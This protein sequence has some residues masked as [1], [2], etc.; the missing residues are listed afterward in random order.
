MAISDRRKR[1]KKQRKESI[2]NAAEMLFFTKGYDEVSLNDI[3]QKVEL[4]RAT[5]YLYFENKEAL[6]FSVILRGMRI[7]QDMVKKYV[8]KRSDPIHK[9]N[10]IGSSYY[11]FFQ[12]Y[13]QYFKVYYY[14]QSGRFDIKKTGYDNPRYNNVRWDIEEILKIQREIFEILHSSVKNYLE[15]NDSVDLDSLYTTIFIMST[16]DGMINPSPVIETELKDMKLN[17]Y[18]N[19]NVIFLKFVNNFLNNK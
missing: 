14:F 17:E 3:A 18:Q 5:I 19:F 7:L 16:L 9:I 6:S 10:A 15:K 11:M 1:E 4:N 13:P 12:R 8:E 2:I